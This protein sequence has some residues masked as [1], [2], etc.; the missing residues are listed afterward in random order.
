MKY[1]QIKALKNLCNNLDSQPCY[2]EVIELINNDDNNFEVDNVRFIKESDILEILANELESD[3][4]L[5]GCFNAEFLSGVIDIEQ[6]VIEAMQEVEA[7]EA[8]GK[9]I[10]SLGKVEAVAEM[11]S[12][13]DGYG[14]HFNGYDFSMEEIKINDELYY[15]FDNR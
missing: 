11:Y 2:R 5:L 7:Y 8:V 13:L 6:D 1:S 4:Y 9:L 15:I 10:I 12:D 3:L 14:H